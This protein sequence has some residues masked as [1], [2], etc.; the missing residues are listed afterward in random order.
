MPKCPI[1]TFLFVRVI[2]VVFQYSV[3]F[4]WRWNYLILLGAAELLESLK[5]YCGSTA[6]FKMA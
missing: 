5:L 6:P 4:K 2:Q 3:P 1:W